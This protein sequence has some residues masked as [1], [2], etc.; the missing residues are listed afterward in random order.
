MNM[1]MFHFNQSTIPNANISI[2]MLHLNHSIKSSK[3]K[4]L[5]K[6]TLYKFQWQYLKENFFFTQKRH[7]EENPKSC[8]SYMNATLISLINDNFSTITIAK[9]TVLFTVHFIL[10]KT[11]PFFF[12]PNIFDNLGT[13]SSNNFYFLFEKQVTHLLFVAWFTC[14]SYVKNTNSNNK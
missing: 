10:N 2:L 11:R 1:T 13:F 3:L 12:Q 7:N 4:P 8:S 9:S 5:G 14:L 6:R